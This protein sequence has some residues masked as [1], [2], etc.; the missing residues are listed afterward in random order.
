MDNKHEKTIT[1]MGIIYKGGDTFN[2]GYEDKLGQQQVLTAR[3]G[4]MENMHFVLVFI[5]ISWIYGS[6]TCWEVCHVTMYSSLKPVLPFA[7]REKL[8]FFFFGPSVP[9]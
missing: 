3:G 6:S 2:D 8:I 5:Y 4:W 9:K 7:L 1:T